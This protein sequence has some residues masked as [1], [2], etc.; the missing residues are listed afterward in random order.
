MPISILRIIDKYI[1]WLLVLIFFPFKYIFSSKKAKIKNNPSKVL[2]I[3]LRALWSSLLT[4]PMIKQLQNY[5]WNS[6]QYDLLAT[7]RNI[8]V[9]KNQWYFNKQYNLF[10]LK[11]L[12]KLIF[13][14]KTYDIVIDAEEYFMISALI[15]IRLGKINVWYNN[16]K[17]RSLAYLFSYKYSEK[18]HNLINCLGLLSK[19]WI[20]IS[21]PDFMEKLV[22]QEKDKIKI[23]N[24]L[25]PFNNKKLIC[26]HTWWAETSPD[27]FW[28]NENWVKLIEE[29]TKMHW[30]SIVILLSWTKFEEKW[31]KEIMSNLND[32]KSIINI[33]WMF[34]LFEFAYLLEH[35][36]LM[37][38]N[39]TGPMHLSACMWT[40]TIGL[41]GPNIPTI[42][43]PWPLNKN[44]W[45]YKWAG[46]IC[47]QPH[48]WIFKKDLSNNINK[49]TQEDISKYTINF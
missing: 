44:L 26:L 18:Q 10:K 11:D 32:T 30:D 4:F 25:K 37:I 43:G 33:C 9:F 46:N 19:L 12:I 21:K 23:E 48:L 3:R 5:Y 31:V 20:K 29:L 2:I 41:F 7:S 24:F 22:Y 14:F 8:W 6:I 17:I 27:R 28:A 35:C 13:S 1:I 39:D 34:N 49:I 45:I 36:D 38:S 15:S 16:I 47:I 40:K 42:F